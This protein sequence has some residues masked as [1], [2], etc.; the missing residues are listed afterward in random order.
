MVV[1][2][3]SFQG[4]R[5]T[6]ARALRRLSTITMLADLTSIS[7]Q[8][9]SR[10]EADEA[11]PTESRL[12]Q[13]AGTLNLPIEFFL[14]APTESPQAP[15]LFRS[16]KSAFRDDR[17]RAREL[18]SLTH[19]VA[20]HL[21]AFVELPPFNLPRLNEQGDVLGL[22]DEAIEEAAKT[23]RRTFGYPSGPLPNLVA[24]A[25]R[26]GVIVIRTELAA[27]ELDGVSRWYEGQPIV[28]INTTKS[29]ARSR[30]DLA[31]E[32]GHIV[33]HSYLPAGIEESGT[34]YPKLEAQAHRFAGA[35]LLPAAEFASDLWLR[36]LDELVSLK[37]RWQVSVQAMAMRANHL[38][39]IS[40]DE[41][42]R[43][44][45]KMSA[46]KWRTEEPL[47]TVV[48]VETPTVIR[49]SFEIIRDETPGG[50]ET[51][52]QHLPFGNVLAEIAGVPLETLRSDRRP[53]IVDIRDYRQSP[54]GQRHSSLN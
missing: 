4:H 10:Y 28:I 1:G 45:K 41:Y 33:L 38:D 32:L 22:T 30:F 54:N 48:R 47:E 9:I 16:M 25:E 3:S 5:L 51:I 7:K 19:E 6:Q 27:R 39:L 42:T 43:M 24:L 31:H 11:K 46:R 50:F 23:V 8:M 14:Q 12:A 44:Q 34:L 35:L 53:R 18:L 2:I 13:L 37:Q 29:P 36:D 40:S 20:S 21:E 17:N 49:Q 52:E 15:A 26:S